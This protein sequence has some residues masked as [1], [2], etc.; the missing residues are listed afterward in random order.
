MRISDIIERLGRTV[1]EAPFGGSTQALSESPEA[2][3]VRIA[4]LDEVRNKIQR[5]GGKALFPYNVVRIQLR[6]RE[7]DIAIFQRDFFRKFFE[8]EVRRALARDGWQ[9]PSDLRVEVHAIPS[10][11]NGKHKWLGVEV[12]SEDRPAE[13]APRAK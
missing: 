8:D 5:A 2:A 1:F 7:A 9:F 11:L 12:I 10:E 13:P 3:E 6:A 4:V